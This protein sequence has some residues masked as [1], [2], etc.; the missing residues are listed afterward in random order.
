MERVAFLIE[1]TNERLSALL[2]PETVRVRRQSGL[3][4]LDE[5]PGTIAGAGGTDDVLIATAGG[6]TEIELDLVF[7]VDMVLT[8]PRPIDVRELTGPI[9]RLSENAAAG[10]PQGFRL[11]WGDRWN[12]PL[13]IEAISERFDRFD[14]HGNPLRSWLSMRA[15]RTGE[16][17]DATSGVSSDIRA[18]YEVTPR[19]PSVTGSAERSFM[20][21]A[22]GDE[23]QARVDEVADSMGEAPQ[24]WR[25]IADQVDPDLLPWVDAGVRLTLGFG[26][27]VLDML[28]GST[29]GDTP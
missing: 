9:W 27:T 24:D 20:V 6:R 18:V 22:T 10:R 1:E 17:D 21:L 28:G 12:V 19:A 8:E 5:R 4:V 25:P 7:D 26:S 14:Q 2:N 13:V 16:V 15:L 3:R 23:G 11:I 29:T